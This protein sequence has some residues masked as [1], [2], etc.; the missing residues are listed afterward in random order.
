MRNRVSHVFQATALEIRTQYIKPTCF[1]TNH[2]DMHHSH[3][4]ENSSCDDDL[5]V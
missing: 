3:G 1:D 4:K 5:L 2:A